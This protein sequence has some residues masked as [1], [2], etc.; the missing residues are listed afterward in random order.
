M[1][2]DE[3]FRNV[4]NRYRVRTRE[5]GIGTFDAYKVGDKVHVVANGQRYLIDL[6]EMDVYRF[7]FTKIENVYTM[8]F[9]TQYSFG[10]LRENLLSNLKQYMMNQIVEKMVSHSTNTR[11]SVSMKPV[12]LNWF[13]D[14]FPIQTELENF[15]S[16]MGVNPN[17]TSA[18]KFEEIYQGNLRDVDESGASSGNAYKFIEG[19]VRT[20]F[21]ESDQYQSMLLLVDESSISVPDRPI[22]GSEDTFTYKAYFDLYLRAS[23]EI[24]EGMGD[25][26]RDKCMIGNAVIKEVECDVTFIPT[27]DH[28]ASS[29]DC[30]E[31]MKYKVRYTIKGG[32][33]SGYFD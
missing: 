2:V 16:S 33:Y 26:A 32:T 18:L 10:Q 12:N 29:S 13:V 21:T 27:Y 3:D 11:L 9:S 4:V 23:K 28:P 14:L 15:T 22:G 7:V 25:S 5:D 31:S 1:E 6:Q 8:D 24:V 20:A 30:E 19:K 17:S